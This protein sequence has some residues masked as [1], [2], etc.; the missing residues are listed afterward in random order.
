MKKE[1]SFKQSIYH[2]FKRLTDNGFSSFI[3]HI[4]KETEVKIGLFLLF[5]GA[6]L[7]YFLLPQ[8]VLLLSIFLLLLFIIPTISLCVFYLIASRL[9]ERA[10]HTLKKSDS[11]QEISNNCQKQE[12]AV[13]AQTIEKDQETYEEASPFRALPPFPDKLHPNL[14]KKVKQIAGNLTLKQMDKKLKKSRRVKLFISFV[15]IAILYAPV[16]SLGGPIFLPT[17]ILLVLVL[18]VLVFLIYPNRVYTSLIIGNVV[19]NLIQHRELD[20]TRGLQHIRKFPNKYYQFGLET[21]S[22]R[23]IKMESVIHP[24]ITEEQIYFIH[25]NG[26][27]GISDKAGVLFKLKPPKEVGAFTPQFVVT[28]ENH[29]PDRNLFEYLREIDGQYIYCEKRR[30]VNLT[31]IEALKNITAPLQERDIKHIVYFSFQEIVIYLPYFIEEKEPLKN[32]DVQYVINKIDFIA[33][34]YAYTLK[35]RPVKKYTY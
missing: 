34:F 33:H 9:G 13:P 12:D 16:I 7:L 29:Q 32:D 15:I 19:G 14:Y 18:V 30:A 27:K 17:W 25:Y 3:K 31:T 23:K 28:T 1:L 6:W 11:S 22:S 2:T 20:Q 24:L 26:K 4:L 35:W 8:T 5:V 21:K 10:T